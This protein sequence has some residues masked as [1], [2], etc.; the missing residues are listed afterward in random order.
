[1]LYEFS[2]CIVRM[3]FVTTQEN[4]YNLTI[5]KINKINGIVYAGI[6]D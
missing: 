3:E 4:M 5:K 1:M 6:N 2:S